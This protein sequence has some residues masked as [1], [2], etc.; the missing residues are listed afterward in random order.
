M[1]VIW[2]QQPNMANK[3]EWDALWTERHKLR[4]DQWS[5]ENEIKYEQ[6]SV[7]MRWNVNNGVENVTSPSFWEFK[8]FTRRSKIN[9]THSLFVCLFT[10]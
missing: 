5:V 1:Y 7:E 3:C 6:W 8:N 4:H 10:K 2:M 9:V